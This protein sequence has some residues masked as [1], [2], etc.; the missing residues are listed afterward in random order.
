MKSITKD[1]H[2]VPLPKP[3]MRDVRD[4]QLTLPPT[5]EAD[6]L[7]LPVWLDPIVE[8]SDEDIIFFGGA[9]TYGAYKHIDKK[10]Q[11][12]SGIIPEEVKVVW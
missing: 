6:P 10:I 12:V 8:D 3:V 1:I 5:L 11:P 4:T 2:I 9:E 7:A